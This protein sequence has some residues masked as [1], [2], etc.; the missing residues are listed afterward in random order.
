M[1]HFESDAAACRTLLWPKEAIEVSIRQGRVRPGGSLFTP[2]SFIGTSHRLIIINRTRL[3][4]CMNFEIMEYNRITGIKVEHGLLSS[5]IVV[6]INGM[7]PFSIGAKGFKGEGI[8][9]G[10][11]PKDAERFVDYLNKKLEREH[12]TKE[13]EKQES[14]ETH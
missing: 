7:S 4:L 6:R 13:K 1:S 9:N 14:A 12:Y 5:S 2:T 10:V 8:I 3:G 11:P